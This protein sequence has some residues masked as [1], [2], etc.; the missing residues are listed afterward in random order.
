MPRSPKGLIENR[1]V[2]PEEMAQLGCP[3]RLDSVLEAVCRIA[4]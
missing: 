3:D 1:S 2:T 4:H